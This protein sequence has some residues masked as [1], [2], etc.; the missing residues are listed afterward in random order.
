M[1]VY[2]CLHVHKYMQAQAGLEIKI[3]DAERLHRV[4]MQNHVW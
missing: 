4:K 3:S 2:I 1:F